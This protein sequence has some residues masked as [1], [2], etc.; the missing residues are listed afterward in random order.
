[1]AD[2]EAGPLPP[3]MPPA[4]EPGFPACGM[5]A[6]EIGEL[7]NS[8][9]AAQSILAIAAAPREGVMT[10]ATA[11]HSEQGS[12]A[13]VGTQLATPY[14]VLKA[15]LVSQGVLQT[16]FE[17]FQPLPFLN[18]SLQLAFMGPMLAGG[19]LS[20]MMLTPVGMLMS[21]VNPMGQMSAEFITGA[22]PTSG[23]TSSRTT[24]R[25]WSGRRR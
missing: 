11:V 12:Q 25:S 7:F 5:F 24:R 19:A 13:Q 2:D 17:Q 4:N 1:M 20:T 10:S 18:C 16:T 15:E 23:S 3:G 21:S 6:G 14:G 22:S 8:L 9:S